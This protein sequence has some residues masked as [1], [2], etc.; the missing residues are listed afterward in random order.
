MIFS[1]AAE[2]AWLRVA[3][4]RGGTASRP[5][6]F[7]TGSDRKLRAAA[8]AT[9]VLPQFRFVAPKVFDVLPR[10]AIDFGLFVNEGAPVV[11][12]YPRRGFVSLN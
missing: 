2:V 10:Q 6:R 5:R 9:R 11:A 4:L 1:T 12:V 7:Q 8:V 3:I